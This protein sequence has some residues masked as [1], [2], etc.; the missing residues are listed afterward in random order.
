MQEKALKTEARQGFDPV[1]LTQG[2]SGITPAKIIAGLVAIG[3]V[4]FLLAGVIFNP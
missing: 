4:I 1:K 2:S 3:V